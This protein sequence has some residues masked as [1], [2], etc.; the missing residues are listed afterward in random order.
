MP[1]PTQDQLMQ[2]LKTK[3][4]PQFSINYVISEKF[5]KA[6]PGRQAETTLSKK[7]VQGYN[8]QGY[9]LTGYIP[10]TQPLACR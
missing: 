2:Q 4:K 9:K 10:F 7:S 3:K 1:L 6:G 8:L 5:Q